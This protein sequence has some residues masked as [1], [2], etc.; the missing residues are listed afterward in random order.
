MM[1]SSCAVSGQSLISLPSSPLLRG[2]PIFYGMSCAEKQ[3][4]P[5]RVPVVNWLDKMTKDNLLESGRISG[6]AKRNTR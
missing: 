5:E 1:N 4:R 6:S 2:W 3:Q